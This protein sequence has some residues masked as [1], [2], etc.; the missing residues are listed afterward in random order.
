AY[1][2][3]TVKLFF[4]DLKYTVPSFATEE[5]DYTR[6]P[7]SVMVTVNVYK[8]GYAGQS[9]DTLLYTRTAMLVFAE[10]TTK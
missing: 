9:A 1:N 5:N 3:Y 8:S 4:S 6:R 2:G 7:T 10:D